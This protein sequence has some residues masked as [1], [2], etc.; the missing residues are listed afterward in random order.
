M[1]LWI[2]IIRDTELR[3]YDKLSNDSLLGAFSTYEDA[4]KAVNDKF[5][6]ILDN[7]DVLDDMGTNERGE[8]YL[9][10]EKGVNVKIIKCRVDEKRGGKKS[11]KNLSKKTNKKQINYSRK[12]FNKM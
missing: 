9:Y 11:K 10:I 12:I 5:Q 4:L 1:D 6:Q 3:G 8:T 7:G 2:V